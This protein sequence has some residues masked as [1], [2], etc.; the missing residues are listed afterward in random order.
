MPKR[1]VG[2]NRE[3]GRSLLE[4]LLVGEVRRDVGGIV[5][6][7][8]AGWCSIFVHF[9][10]DAGR[11]LL[12]IDVGAEGL[13]EAVHAGMACLWVVG[14]VGVVGDFGGSDGVSVFVGFEE[15]SSVLVLAHGRQVWPMCRPIGAAGGC[16]FLGRSRQRADALVGVVAGTR[17]VAG[18]AG[19][20]EARWPRCRHV[21]H[22]PRCR[23]GR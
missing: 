5:G 21:R 19:H 7:V 6:V 16:G 20:L 3:S 12:G 4:V 10:N 9:L 8:V 23:R 18:A 13:L 11:S 2:G 17:R 1:V 15:C 14:A 22:R